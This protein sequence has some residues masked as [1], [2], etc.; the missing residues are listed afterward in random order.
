M[1]FIEYLYVAATSLKDMLRYLR[2]DFNKSAK[3]HIIFIGEPGV[4]A[5]SPCSDVMS[6]NSLF[7]GSDD[8]HIPLHNVMELKNNTYHYVGEIMALSVVHGGPGPN[9]LSPAVVDNL[10]YGLQKIRGTVDDIPNESIRRAV[11][12]VLILLIGL[13]NNKTFNYDNYNY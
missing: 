2:K 6:N 1:T 9:C 3:L 13:N 11:K 4:D 7:E 5:G 8:H 12:K 10:C